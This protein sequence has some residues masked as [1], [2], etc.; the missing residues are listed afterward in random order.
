[1]AEQE[2]ALLA[3]VTVAVVERELR[4]IGE[5]ELELEKAQAEMNAELMEVTARHE[6][7]VRPLKK[8]AEAL[9]DRLEAAVSANRADLFEGDSQ[10]LKLG[11]GKVSFRRAPS[12]VEPEDGVTV[13]E[14]VRRML[15]ARKRQYVKRTYS[16]DKASLNTAASTGVLDEEA[17]AAFGLRLVTGEESWKVKTDHEAVREAVGKS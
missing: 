11:M 1:M 13:E 2:D 12:R 9:V 15:S 5:A 6:A 3:N 10:T 14:V 8:K 7:I 17:L 4:K 16:L